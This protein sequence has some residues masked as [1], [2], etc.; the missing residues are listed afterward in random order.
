M[1]SL[2]DAQRLLRRAVIAGDASEA[3]PLLAGGRTAEKRLTIHHRH[4]ETSLVTALLGKFPATA[5]L[6]G[7]RY[8]TEAAQLFVRDHP[9]Q[10]L[11]ISEYGEQFPLFLATSPAADRVPYVRDFAELEWHVG[12]VSIAVD[13]QALSLEEFSTVDTVKLTE[14]ALTLQAGVRYLQA[15]WPIDALMKLY[16]AETAPDQLTFEPEDVCIEVRGARGE[17]Q[18][19]RLDPGEFGFRKALRDGLLVGDAANCALAGFDPGQAFVRLV[20]A[21]LVVAVTP[22]V[23]EGKP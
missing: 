19:N 9:P 1:A 3:I 6:I 5:W 21:G 22:A 20:A 23:R 10:A 12:Q 7:T 8:L 14:A 2:A 15:P 17:V 18:I 4:Y 13:R 16:L 11:C